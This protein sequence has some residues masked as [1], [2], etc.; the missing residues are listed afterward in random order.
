MS[1]ALVL[2]ATPIGNLGD[3]SPRAVQ[4]LSEAD[5]IL[6]EDTRRSRQL[7]THAGVTGKRLV[8]MDAHREAQMSQRVLEWVRE[9]RTVALVTDAGMPAVSDPGARLVAAA[10]AAGVEVRVVP[11][12]SAV[13]AALALSGL[14]TERFVFEGFLPRRGPARAERLASLAR[15]QLTAVIFE[16]PLRVAATLRELAEAC[17]PGRRVAVVRELT[18]LHEEVWRG[19]L[20]G[21]AELA[22]VGSPRGEHVIV[23][24]GRHPAEAAPPDEAV[25]SALATHLALGSSARDAARA[26]ADELGIP[27]RRAYDLALR[28]NGR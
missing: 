26:V 5:V 24:A 15:C 18:K 2:V 11:G 10:V 9:G 8:A 25:E 28:L 12:P 16:S 7:L 27:K 20:G 13:L 14:V 4:T 22:E 23:L 19:P 17:G 6:C 3:L 1:A 21:A